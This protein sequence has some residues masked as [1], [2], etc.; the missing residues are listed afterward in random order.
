MVG[1]IK[2][3]SGIKWIDIYAKRDIEFQVAYS[4]LPA[5][6]NYIGGGFHI[7]RERNIVCNSN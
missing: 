5:Y 6:S 3:I 7:P 1:N 4:I 2:W